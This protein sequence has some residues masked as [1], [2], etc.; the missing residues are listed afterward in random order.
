MLLFCNTITTLDS[1]NIFIVD[2]PE[3]S[4]NIKWQRKLL[5]SLVNCIGNKPVQ[6]IFATYSMEILS[7]HMD[8][9]VKLKSVGEIAEWH[10][11]QTLNL[12]NE[13]E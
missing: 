4:L 6:Y 11:Q 12:S 8:K 1:P 5:D 13:L 9:V 3:L 7:R 10:G 2:E